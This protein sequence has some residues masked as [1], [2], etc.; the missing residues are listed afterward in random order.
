MDQTLV[1]E[2]APPYP[3]GEPHLGHFLEGSFANYILNICDDTKL[4]NYLFDQFKIKVNTITLPRVRLSYG[5]DANGLPL[6]LK[7]KKENPSLSCQ[8]IIDKCHQEVDQ[9]LVRFS[10]F[11]HNIIGLNKQLPMFCTSTGL[12]RELTN[13]TFERLVRENIIKTADRAALFCENCQTTLSRSECDIVEVIEPQYLLTAENKGEFYKIMTTKPEL[14]FAAKAIA[15]HPEDT[16]YNKLEKLTLRLSAEH[17]VLLPVVKTHHIDPEK[18]SGLCYVA[19]YGSQMDVAILRDKNYP[20]AIDQE[21]KVTVGLSALGYNQPLPYKQY[22]KAF[23]VKF[24]LPFQLGKVKKLVHTER[25]SCKAQILMTNSEQLVIP[26]EG[27]QPSLSTKLN[28]L[29]TNDRSALNQLETYFK[30][31]CAWNVSRSANTYAISVPY[32]GKNVALDTWFTSSLGPYLDSQPRLRIQGTDILRTWLTYSLILGI[33]CNKD[34]P[35][36]TKLLLHRMV[37][38]ENRRKFSK[39]S[40]DRIDWSKMNATEILTL[41]AYLLSQNMTREIVYSKALIA[42]TEKSLRKLQNTLNFLLNSASQYEFY[43]KEN[44]IK[45]VIL[46]IEENAQAIINLDQINPLDWNTIYWLSR[47]FIPLMKEK[48]VTTEQY[49]DALSTILALHYTVSCL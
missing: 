15:C 47:T 38:D 4:K 36:I 35:G 25:S 41:K 7:V 5:I 43:S 21:G 6:Y 18:G 46:K 2:L 32:E 39:S 22:R 26:S 30:R 12:H 14:F 17:S 9:G 31:L 44:V 29:V 13:T 40:G 19:T 11:Y 42:K 8:Q 27:L 1:I 20:S 34:S 10:H 3:N 28:A 49:E 16:R 33:I 24:P 23:L 37:V 48:K 45:K